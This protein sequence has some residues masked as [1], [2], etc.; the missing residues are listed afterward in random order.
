MARVAEGMGKNYEEAVNDAL[1]KIGLNKDEVLIE[2]IEEPK[3]RI[4]SI[5]E[6]R[7]VKV[8]VTEIEKNVSNAKTKNVNEYVEKEILEIT[9][10]DANIAKEKVL[11][12]LNEFSEKMGLTFNINSYISD[13]AL[14]FDIT[15]EN[16]GI[17]IGY[18]GETLEALQML[19]ST[20]GNKN[21]K[22]YVRIII[23]IEGY[24][25][26]RIRALEELALKRAN[27]VV[28]KKKSITLEPMNPFERKAIHKALQNHPKVKTVST[29]EEPY[30]KVVISLK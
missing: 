15:G 17:M 8:K 30:R 11:K 26:K 4:F 21:C 22:N 14:K 7:Q 29:G 2:L 5:L 12:F 3:K 10:E 13:N 19:A 1:G 28:A 23:D 20:I 16:A 9:E 25:K 18:R 6:S 27:L 24:R